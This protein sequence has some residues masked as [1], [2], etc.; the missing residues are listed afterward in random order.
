MNLIPHGTDGMLKYAAALASL[1]A[2]LADATQAECPAIIGELERLK[3]QAW[4]K[5]TSTTTSAS[6]WTALFLRSLKSRNS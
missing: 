3:A 1:E 4:A 2:S 5:M 6:R